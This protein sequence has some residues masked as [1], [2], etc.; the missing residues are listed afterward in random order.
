MTAKKVEY[1]PTILNTVRAMLEQGKTEAQVAKHFGISPRT[2]LDWKKKYP[3]LNEAVESATKPPAPDKYNATIPNQVLYMVATGNKTIAQMADYLGINEKTWH[4][5]EQKYP[6]FKEAV[7]HGR[8][9]ILGKLTRT[10]IERATQQTTVIEK[11]IKYQLKE[12]PAYKT[13][14]SQPQYLRVPYEEIEN[15]KVQMPDQSAMKQALVGF[16]RA[17]WEGKEKEVTPPPPPK[18]EPT[19]LDLRV[20]ELMDH[21]TEEDQILWDQWEHDRPDMFMRFYKTGDANE[22]AKYIKEQIEGG[23]A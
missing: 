22:V 23:K 19:P 6:E 17:Q 5:W 18:R 7:G 10:L 16:D 2:F 4:E 3:E 11:Q 8:M 14:K 15:H 1:A 21:L 13:D 9:A 12:N 20:K